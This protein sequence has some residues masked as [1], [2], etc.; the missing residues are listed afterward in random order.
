MRRAREREKQRQQ[1]SGGDG[2][3]I[4]RDVVVPEV[5]TVQ[6]LANRMA[7]RAAD[8]VRALMKMGVMASLSQT[9][10]ADTAELI[11]EE[12]GHNIRRVA[13]SDVE[14]GLTGPEDDDAEMEARPPVV[15]I[16]G[17]VAHGK[18]SLLGAVRQAGVVSGGTGLFRLLPNGL[19]QRVL[20]LMTITADG[21]DTL[22]PAPS[23][24]DDLTY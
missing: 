18:P 3:K 6:D 12:F 17:H 5:I 10:D 7:E 4:V 16:M 9:I 11:V 24:F 20:A 15:T 14:E 8:V 21:L 13:G 1:Q 2:Q 22:D 23:R 19:N